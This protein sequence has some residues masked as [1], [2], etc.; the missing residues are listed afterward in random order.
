M[1]NLGYFCMSSRD[2]LSGPTVCLLG[3]LVQPHSLCLLFGCNGEEEI[4]WGEKKAY[5]T[6]QGLCA[7]ERNTSLASLK[8]RLSVNSVV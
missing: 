1:L 6:G 5:G 4:W 2:R 3:W 7:L 8:P